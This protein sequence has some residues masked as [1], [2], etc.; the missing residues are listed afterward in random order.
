MRIAL[1]Q[2]NTTVGDFAGNVERMVRFAREGARRGADL[3]VFP[4]LAI[5]G[6]PPRDLV[7]VP[8]FVQRS[9][10]ELER[11]ATQA[12]EVHILAGYVR[13]SGANP[14]KAV[15]D[16]AALL[17]GGRRMLTYDKM[18]LAFYDVFDESRYFEPGRAPGFY[19]LKGFRLGVT[20]CED[21]WNDKNFWN[22]QLYARDPVEDTAHGGANLLLNLAS[23]PFAAGKLELRYRMLRAIAVERRLPVVYVNQVGGNDQLVFDGSSMA[24]DARG[25]VVARARCF[26]EDLVLFDVESSTGDVRPGPG[27]ETEAIYEA[28]KLGTRDYVAKCGFRKALVGLSGGIDSSLVA[29]LAADALGPENVYGVSMPGPFSSPGSLT[30]AEALAREL[31]ISYQVIPI[32]PMFDVYSRE[33]APVFRNL[34]ADV[35]EENLQARIRGT[36]LMAL[37]NKFGALLLS[38]GNKSELAVGYCTLYGDMAGGLAVIADVPKTMVYELAR[39]VNRDRERI[40]LASLIKP[41]SAELR[42]NQTDQDS[43]PPYEVL[44]AILRAYIEEHQCAEQ[45]GSR[46]GLDV[47]LVHGIIRRVNLAEYKRQQAAPALKVTAKAFGMGRRYPI[48]NRYL[49]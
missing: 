29:A 25:E 3:V 49:E 22:Q 9:E 35:T 41:P 32:G 20:I 24:L 5:T 38:T 1:A 40:P 34:A 8:H 31:G 12:P 13:R 17:Y 39:F 43:L 46:F 10:E 45:I 37:S 48:A 4:E 14:G 28:L 26:E 27:S 6:Y 15:S 2:I 47:E 33:L 36:I 7:E 44:D 23:S 11:L 30:D 18:L 19:E 16:S 42:A 21:V